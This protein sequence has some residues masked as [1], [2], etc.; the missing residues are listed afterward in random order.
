[1]TTYIKNN[2]GIVEYDFIL[3]SESY[4]VG[5]TYED[6]LNGAW[7]MLSEDHL[8]FRAKY[9]NCTYKEMFDLELNIIQQPSEEELLNQAKTNKLAQIKRYDTSKQV[10]SFYLNEEQVWLD[11]S[12]RVGLMNSM[13]IEKSAGRTESTLWF[14]D[15]Y[16]TVSI[17]LGIQMLQ[18]LEL[19]ALACYNRTSEH[20]VNV[21]K[22]ETL[23]EVENYDYTSGYPE[24]LTFNIMPI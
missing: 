2:V 24:K 6:Y 7:V 16:Y 21:Q 20:K 15:K 11:K 8:A 13:Q 1:M 23:Q 17:D 3:D 9:P 4:N 22:L 14:N 12:M 5:N 10:N 19:Y 18:V